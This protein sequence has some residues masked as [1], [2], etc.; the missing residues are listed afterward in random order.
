MRIRSIRKQVLLA[1]VLAGILSSAG[2]A[3]QPPA[4][5]AA[6]P[7]PEKPAATAPQNDSEK[8]VLKVGTQN[9]TQGDMEFLIRSLSPQL[10]QVVA[11][12]GK[13]PLGDQYAMMAVLS[14]QGE[15][16]H[17][18]AST[19]FHEQMALHRLQALA[20]AEYDKVAAD[21]K[22]SPEEISQY[23]TAHAP[24]FDQAQV[25]EFVIRK[26]AEG[27]KDDASGL[28][29]AEAHSRADEI[30]KALAAGTD[31][32]KV[33]DQFAAENTVMIDAEP[34]TVKHGQLI[35][36]LD[37]AAFELKDGGVSDPF[38]NAQALA[39][40]QV[41]GHT[42]QD[43]KDVSSDIENTLHQQKLE[44]AVEELK[45][46]SN[47]WMDEEYFKAPAEAAEPQTAAPKQ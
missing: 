28:T 12:Q 37:K 11:R 22:I 3:Q 42:H 24:E 26:K 5:K 33:A 7:A 14:Q 17:L 25:R 31:P 1:S 4:A 20:Q 23:Y 46:K 41:V 19:T 36:S 40:L 44:A 13:K 30:R 43:L 8:V 32:K 18:D 6:A 34:R 2:W 29:A 16:D 45:K 38:E 10:Q 27:G 39:F 35:A 15:K 47:V 21:I 9:F